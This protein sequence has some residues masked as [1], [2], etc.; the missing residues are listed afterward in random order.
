M[1]QNSHNIWLKT[2]IVGKL[3]GNCDDWTDEAEKRAIKS[4]KQLIKQN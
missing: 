1:T 4:S 3:H 2:V